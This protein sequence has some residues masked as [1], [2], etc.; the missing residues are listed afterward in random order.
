MNEEEQVKYFFEKY[1]KATKVNYELDNKIKKHIKK[2][3]NRGDFIMKK[4]LTIGLL[5]LVT[6][7]PATI[8]AYTQGYSVKDFK[9]SFEQSNKDLKDVLNIIEAS[10]ETMDVAKNN[11]YFL[12]FLSE[13][14][15]NVVNF[16]DSYNGD[17]VIDKIK[18]ADADIIDFNIKYYEY[19]YKGEYGGNYTADVIRELKDNTD[20]YYTGIK[21]TSDNTGTYITAS[22]FINIKPSIVDADYVFVKQDDV[23]KALGDN[24][25]VINALSDKNTIYVIDGS[26]DN[27]YHGSGPIYKTTLGNSIGEQIGTLISRSGQ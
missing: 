13:D 23:N 10:D 26:A 12:S 5:A 11:K 14:M 17:K 16:S 25:N 20:G 15:Y 6:V 19:K 21:K 1:D 18:I 4:R 8:F 7:F 24:L 2:I 27:E 9:M 3:E 22:V